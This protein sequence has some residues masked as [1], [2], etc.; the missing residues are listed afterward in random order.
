[1]RG[2]S[3]PTTRVLHH[4]Y[5]ITPGIWRFLDRGGF[6]LVVIAGW[7]VFAAQAAILW[8]RLHR[9]PYLLNAENHFREPRPPWVERVKGLAPPHVIP[10]AAGMLV[11]GR[12]AREHALYY[13]AR[14]ERVIVFPNTPDIP[15]FAAKADDLR[16]GRDATRPELGIDADD[17]VVLQ[18]GRLIPVKGLDILVAAVGIAQRD[19]SVRMRLLLAGEGPERGNLEALAAR[20]GVSLTLA[21]EVEDDELIALYVAA[22]IFALLSR[23]ETWGI[24]VNEAMATGLPL[25]L[26]SGGR[27]GRGP[28]ARGGERPARGA[29]GRAGAAAAL[30]ALAGDAPRRR[31]IWPAVARPGRRLGLRAEPR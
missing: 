22:D 28:S 29:R 8:C 20:A 27:G 4:D 1:M 14:A 10:Q 15:Q 18:V 13:G 26:S 2:W 17:V 7:A 24:V 12:L 23:R 19:A 31:R 11:S 6:D 30:S 9:V 16:P 21:G 3:L 5:P 25:V